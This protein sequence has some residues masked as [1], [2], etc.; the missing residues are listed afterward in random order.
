MD[1]ETDGVAGL[2]SVVGGKLTPHRL[3]AEA[4]A[5]RVCAA[6]GVDARCETAETPLPSDP[7]RVA[8]L[9]ERYDAASPAEADLR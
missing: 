2:T 6:L 4:T 9:V 8:S 5:D 1:H 7:D 3:M